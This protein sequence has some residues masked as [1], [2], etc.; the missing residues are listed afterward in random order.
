MKTSHQPKNPDGFVRRAEGIYQYQASGHYYARFR[1]NGKRIFERLGS[2]KSPCT[3]L[4][5]AKRL[6]RIKKQELEETDVNA[7]KMTMHQ[8]ID[9]RIK[10]LTG[11]EGTVSYKLDYLKQFK[12]FFE[13]GDKLVDVTTHQLRLF[14]KEQSHLAA[15]TLNHIITV[16]REVFQTAKEQRWITSSPMEAI[17]YKKIRDNKK[18]LTPSPEQFEA[19]VASIRAQKFSDTAK[20]TADLVEF[21]GL[22][23]LGQAES[24]GLRWGDV[25]FTKDEIT[26]IRG[27][28]KKEFHIPLYPQLRPLLEGMRDERTTN[29]AE[30]KVFCVAT[31][32]RALQSAC[33]RLGYPYYEPRSLRRMF[34]QT[35]RKKGIPVQYVAKWQGHK[36]VR[37]V[38]KVYDTG[39]DKEGMELA[40]LM[41]KKAEPAVESA[42]PEDKPKATAAA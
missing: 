9:D 40:K 15:A 30:G 39:T 33:K 12:E 5:E 28:T 14:L 16:M 20:D 31:P 13:A 27:K 38:L 34:I 6:L 19:I 2:R 11:A 4:P 36:D 18:R 22:A 29:N 32:K 23:G 1:H 8:A 3:S 26:I 41:A 24:A 21:M 25:N 7:R 35:A 37:M 17:K 10:T 42:N